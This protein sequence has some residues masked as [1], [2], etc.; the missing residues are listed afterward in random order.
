[1]IKSKIITILSQW[2]KNTPLKISVFNTV[3]RILSVDII[4]YNPPTPRNVSHGQQQCHSSYDPLG[5]RL[6]GSEVESPH[7]RGP[8][9]LSAV[10]WTF[11]SIHEILLLCRHSSDI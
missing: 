9:L 10:H 8:T 1:M 4:K 11:E 7:V 2:E 5:R 6:F 3:C